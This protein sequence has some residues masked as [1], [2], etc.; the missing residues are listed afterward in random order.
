MTIKKILSNYY[1]TSEIKPW[2]RYKWTKKQF[3]EKTL[4][5]C[6]QYNVSKSELLEEERIEDL[7]SHLLEKMMYCNFLEKHYSQRIKKISFW[8]QVKNL[9]FNSQKKAIR[10]AANFFKQVER[11]DHPKRRALK[12]KKY[13]KPRTDFQKMLH[14]QLVL[15]GIRK[16][17]P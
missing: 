12:V 15:A 13:S 14:E 7:I 2:E 5:A 6:K 10:E 16:I 3:V 1:K 4:K 9:F 8:E 11:V 17:T